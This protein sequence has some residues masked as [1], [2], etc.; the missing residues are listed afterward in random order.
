MA[1]RDNT[2][3]LTLAAAPETGTEIFQSIGA[4]TTITPSNGAKIL[5]K[6]QGSQIIRI[7]NTAGTAKDV[8]VKA[9]DFGSSG[10]GDEVFE[11]PA[12]GDYVFMPDTSRFKQ[13]DGYIY[14][15]FETGFAGKVW[16]IE[17]N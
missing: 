9:G 13:N 17:V 15:D 11:V 7:T 5:A 12:S 6:A 10:R 1:T 16:S 8:T 14:L 3:V 2:T 4:G